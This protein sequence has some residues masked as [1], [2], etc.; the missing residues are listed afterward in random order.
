MGQFDQVIPPPEEVNSGHF[1][2][3]GTQPK[4]DVCRQLEAT[5]SPLKQTPL[6]QAA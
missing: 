1:L 5:P 4:Y 3:T 6:L 2:P